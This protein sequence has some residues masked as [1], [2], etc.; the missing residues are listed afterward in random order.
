LKSQKFLFK[1][2]KELG[3]FFNF[4]SIEKAAGGGEALRINRPRGEALSPGPC[5]KPQKLLKIVE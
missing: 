1:N 4:A 2:Y 3:H 5:R